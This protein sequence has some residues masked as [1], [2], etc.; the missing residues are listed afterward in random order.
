MHARYFSQVPEWKLSRYQT[1]MLLTKENP[2]QL[3]KPEGRPIPDDVDQTR[4][5]LYTQV[6]YLMNKWKVP[7]ELVINMDE[8]S[9]RTV[10]QM[11]RSWSAKHRTCKLVFHKQFVTC[12]MSITASGLALP[13]Q[14]IWHGKTK[15]CEGPELEFVKPMAIL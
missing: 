12:C 7:P 1:Y 2:I 13:L 4:S 11:R 6:L 15:R 9:I 14:I 5:R 10:P 3:G 8:T